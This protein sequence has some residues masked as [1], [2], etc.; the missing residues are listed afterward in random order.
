[1][2]LKRQG[3]SGFLQR[4]AKQAVFSA[5][6]AGT[7]A[8][9]AF[10]FLLA[11]LTLI[12]VAQ[13]SFSQ[14]GPQVVK[15]EPP[16][17]W[18]GHSIN[19]VRVLIRG[20][21]FVGAQ[22]Q[23]V[24]PGISA[25]ATKIN[26]AG[27]YLFVD[28]TIARQASAGQRS[29]KITTVAGSIEAP[30]EILAP[31]PRAGRFQGF[32]TD[33]VIYLIMTDRFSD[34]DSSNNDP[35]PS[36]GLYDRSKTRY[37]HG[38]DFEGIIQH[39][40]Y[41]K[42]LG[43]TAIWLTPWYDNVNHLNEREQYPDRP[44]EPKRQI[45][46]Y[47]GY[48]AVD[49]YGVEEHFGTL[50]KL[51]ELVDKAHQLGIKVIQDEVA[52]HTGPYHPWVN[53]PP[54]PTWFNGTAAKHLANVWQTWSVRDPHAT[55]QVQ[56]ETLDGWF[57]DILPDLNQNDPEVA[58]YI[59]QNT[60]WW[61]GVTGIDAIRQ[62]TFQYVPR[63]FWRDW[64]AAI[65]REYPNVN[66]IGEVLDGDVAHTSFFQGGRARYDGIDDGLDTLFDFPLM[67]PLRRAFA[68]GGDIRE[69]PRILASDPLYV[70][71]NVLVP[72]ITNHDLK[73]FM[74]EPG[75]TI[76]GLKM[77]QTLVMTMRGTPQLYYG[78]EIA[79]SGGDD[80]DNRRDFPGGFPADGIDAFHT[81]NANQQSVFEH[82]KLLGR[83]RAELEPLRRGSLINLVATEHQYVYARSTAD[84]SVIVAFNNDQKPA[85]VE[86]SV[87][88]TKVANGV[89]L[90]DRLDNV[91]DARVTNGMT[92]L[93]LPARS[94]AIL[95]RK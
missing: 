1:M 12:V 38:G 46:D 3:R 33:D 11:T 54:T 81:R 79:M 6:S 43:V 94:S 45:T 62:D 39:L 77:A 31:L 30:F 18:A 72:L 35:P 42:E 16:G 41:L 86:F 95:V 65:K 71:A 59:N 8:P 28:V 17:W 7:F 63:P 84:L 64:M 74:N 10:R 60:L 23:T 53:D 15:V 67:Y 58:R 40:G 73:R 80:P 68:A 57:V 19:P 32:T 48:G 34:G 5:A 66:V 69:L 51:R 29:L 52:N 44:G 25:A 61:I 90:T 78:D 20:R 56:R 14:N 75:A 89:T 24:G 21:N 93:E 50:A 27:T 87:A 36:A 88:D 70:N 2:L 85:M 22:V 82:Q 91:K 49:F 55:P 37:Y 9:F 92:K 47:H 76:E 83:L 26:Q 13:V 4:N